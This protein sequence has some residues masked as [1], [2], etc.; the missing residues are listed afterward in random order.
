MGSTDDTARSSSR[1]FSRLPPW[2]R[3]RGEQSPARR[4]SYQA[5]SLEFTAGPT[6]Q[7]HSTLLAAAKF[8]A[9]L[10]SKNWPPLVLYFVRL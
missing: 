5:H 10:I 2:G 1:L 8:K 7:D 9:L 4:A 6:P 3:G